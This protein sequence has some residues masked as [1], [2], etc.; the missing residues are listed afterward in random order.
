MVSMRVFNYDFQNQAAK[1][2]RTYSKAPLIVGVYYMGVG[3]CVLYFL[4][5][6]FESIFNWF[7]QLVDFLQKQTG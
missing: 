1:T 5:V 3:K 2:N 6:C 7:S 4:S